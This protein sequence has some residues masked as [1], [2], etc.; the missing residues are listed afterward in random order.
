M[1]S[2]GLLLAALTVAATLLRPPLRKLFLRKSA[3]LPLLSKAFTD[4]TSSDFP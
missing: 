2:I 1:G 4:A 3:L